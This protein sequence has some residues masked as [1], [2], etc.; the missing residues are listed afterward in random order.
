MAANLP[1]FRLSAAID[2]H[3]RSLYFPPQAFLMPFGCSTVRIAL[4][5]NSKN[6]SPSP[7]RSLI[8][9]SYIERMISLADCRAHYRM[10]RI[11]D[12]IDSTQPLRKALVDRN[13]SQD[14]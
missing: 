7:L 10:Y 13:V 1:L 11:V 2:R 9:R 3:L 12:N 4:R 5:I 6:K 14:L 8:K